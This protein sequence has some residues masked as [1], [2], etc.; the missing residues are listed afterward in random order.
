[1]NNEVATTQPKGIASFLSNDKVKANILQ[2]VGQKNTTRFI[3]SVVSAVQNTPALQECSHNSILSSARK[4][5]TELL[6]LI[7]SCIT[8]PHNQTH[9]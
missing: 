9:L 4:N 3:A 8:P 2:V 7:K 6:R 5:T 1:M